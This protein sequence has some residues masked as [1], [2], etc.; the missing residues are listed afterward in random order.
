M[1]SKAIVRTWANNVFSIR[2][3][4]FKVPRIIKTDTITI[5]Y[6]AY[7]ISSEERF[8]RARREALEA[9]DVSD[10]MSSSVSDARSREICA[11]P[12]STFL[13]S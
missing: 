5:S 8:D 9:R 6:T 10:F 11:Q 12:T 4:G 7:R 2:L 1:Y 3:I 13:V